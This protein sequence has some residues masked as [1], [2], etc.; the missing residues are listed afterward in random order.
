MPSYLPHI[1]IISVY[2]LENVLA[3]EVV[4]LG[5]L[6]IKLIVRNR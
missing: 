3:K 4:N 1:K 6:G 2:F 5:A